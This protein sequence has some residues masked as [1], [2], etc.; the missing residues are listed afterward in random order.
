MT[1]KV[2]VSLCLYLV[3]VLT[4]S[5]QEDIKSFLKS[6]S[7]FSK[8]NIEYPLSYNASPKFGTKSASAFADWIGGELIYPESALKSNVQ[9]KVLVGFTIDTAGNVTNVYVANGIS[10]ELDAEAIRI[11]SASPQWTPA[12]KDGK[13]ISVSYKMPIT[14]SIPDDY[15]YKD[16]TRADT[17]PAANEED[18]LMK[19]FM[20]YLPE[21]EKDTIGVKVYPTFQGQ[22][23]GPGG[24]GNIAFSRW[25]TS[26]IKYPESAARNGIQGK[27]IL[28]FIIDTDG[29][30]TNVNVLK[31]IDRELAK[32]A[33]RVLLSSPKWTP[34][35]VNGKPVKVSF[36]FPVSFVIQAGFDYSGR[37][38]RQRNDIFRNR[39]TNNWNGSF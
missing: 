19:Q 34:G 33:V 39:N 11:V 14:F 18:L 37:E 23:A 12:Y 1:K 9:G 16:L 24:K 28:N 27:V 20:K 22:P 13:P 21:D 7:I 29:K 6:D 36:N 15:V 10:E 17:L 26:R 8:A 2:I 31:S 35:Y 30:I 4:I 32:E 25:V 3:A 5:A 38:S